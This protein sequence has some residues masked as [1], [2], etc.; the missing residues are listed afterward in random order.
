MTSDL[1]HGANGVPAGA[2]VGIVQ[3]PVGQAS[4]SQTLFAAAPISN[5]S[6]AEASVRPLHFGNTSFAAT[7]GPVAE[8]SLPSPMLIDIPE[9]PAPVATHLEFAGVPVQ[10]V[11]ATGTTE[12]VETA[13][14]TVDVNMTNGVNYTNGNNGTTSPAELEATEIPGTLYGIPPASAVIPVIPSTRKPPRPAY[15]PFTYLSLTTRTNE[16]IPPFR[17]DPDN[18]PNVTYDPMSVL[19]GPISDVAYEDWR[20][21]P[22]YWFEEKMKHISSLM[23]VEFHTS[24]D[25]K[26]YAKLYVWELGGWRKAIELFQAYPCGGVRMWSWRFREKLVAPER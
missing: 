13:Q 1:I 11:E 6:M 23:N 12:V 21:E 22:K 25:G 5:V 15:P 2:P 9:L 3:T 7:Q 19:V 17:G 14:T 24:L 10:I 8:E 26:R 16:N 4:S 18:D 20:A